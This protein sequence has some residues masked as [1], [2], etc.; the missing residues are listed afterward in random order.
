MDWIVLPLFL[1]FMK[2]ICKAMPSYFSKVKI[3]WDEGLT[4]SLRDITWYWKALSL[5]RSYVLWKDPLRWKK[6][7]IYNLVSKKIVSYI[8]HCVYICKKS[9]SYWIMQLYWKEKETRRRN[10]SALE[11]RGTNFKQHLLWVF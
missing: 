7:C 3:Q 11:T 10:W 9:E 1:L 5:L 2:Q 6:Q 4:V 8:F